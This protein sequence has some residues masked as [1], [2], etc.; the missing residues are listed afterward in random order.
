MDQLIAGSYARA[1]PEYLAPLR[2]MT[3]WDAANETQEILLAAISDLPDDFVRD[4]D[5]AIHRNALLHP[6][7]VIDDSVVIEAGAIVSE[8]LTR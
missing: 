3:P 6:G 4:G 2:L 8:R 5:S 7:A 1:L